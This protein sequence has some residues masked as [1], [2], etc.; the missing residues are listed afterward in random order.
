MAIIH[1]LIPNMRIVKKHKNLRK[2]IKGIG[3]GGKRRRVVRDR[4]KIVVKP[5]TE[6]KRQKHH[7]GVFL[8]TIY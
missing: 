3:G 5:E 6:R 2:K 8:N 4:Q 1:V 7:F